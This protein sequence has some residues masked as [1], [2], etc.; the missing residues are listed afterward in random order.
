MFKYKKDFNRFLGLNPLALVLLAD[1]NYW[2]KLNNMPFRITSTVSTEKED[3]NLNRVSTTHREGRAFDISVKGWTEKQTERFIYHF[4]NKF[5]LHAAKN[6]EGENRLIVRH[7]GTADHL[8]IQIH[9]SY[10]KFL[11]HETKFWEIEDE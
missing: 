2:C 6:K 4:E 5:A 11:N 7:V 10:N 8:H 9:K 1:M 3:E